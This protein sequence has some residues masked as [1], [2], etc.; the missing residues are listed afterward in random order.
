[1]PRNPRFRPEIIAGGVLFVLYQLI[2]RFTAVALPDIVRGAMLGLTLA[3][4][5]VGL[6]RMTRDVPS[7]E[8]RENS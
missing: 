3:L 1:M 2:T 7:A 6:K 8:S 4:L 5:V